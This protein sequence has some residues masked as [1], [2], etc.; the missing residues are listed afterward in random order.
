MRLKKLRRH[1]IVLFFLI[2]GFSLLGVGLSQHLLPLEQAT[3][4]L[5]RP[6]E[7]MPFSNQPIEPIPPPLI[8][9]QQKV[10]LGKQLFHEPRLSHNNRLSCASCHSL[11]Q[12]GIDR[13]PRSIGLQG[14]PSSFNAPTILNSG[15]NFSQF[16]D[17]RSAT[18]EDQIEDLITKP[19]V[20]GT[21]WEEIIKKLNQEPQYV[22]AFR[23]YPEGIQAETIKDAIATFERSLTT[24]NS[25]FDRFLKGETAALTSSE[26]AGYE[27]FKSYGCIACHQGVNIGGNMFQSL[28]VMAD[29]FKGEGKTPTKADLGRFN[30]T[31]DPRDRHVFKVPSLRNV[32]LTA[33]YFHDGHLKTLPEVVNIMAKYQLGRPIPPEDVALIVQFLQTLTGEVPP[34]GKV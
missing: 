8:L 33:P 5:S 18:L 16:W 1:G 32:A 29:Y 17:G 15:L 25:A 26:K 4:S 24:P 14:T 6:L 13:L 31:G 22:S 19:N 7:Q 2:F 34:R 28:G 30:V 3:A 20:L 12:A 9:D 21:S 11:N 27:R 23:L 10:A